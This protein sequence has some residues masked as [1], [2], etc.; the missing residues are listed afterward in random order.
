MVHDALRMEFGTVCALGLGTALLGVLSL[1]A[2]AVRRGPAPWWHSLAAALAL[3]GAGLGARLAGLPQFAW[4][5]PLVLAGVGAALVGV[6]SP[7]PG[8]VGRGL[9]AA[10]RQ[11]HA[12]A[13]LLLL[14]GV[15]LVVGQL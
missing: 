9:L 2:R 1:L 4:L 13:G 14:V 10:A 11:P 12:Q 3:A 7:L 15:G 5:P 8:H 6:R